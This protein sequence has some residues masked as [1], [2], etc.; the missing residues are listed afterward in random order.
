LQHEVDRL[1]VELDA[2]WKMIDKLR[3]QLCARDEAVGRD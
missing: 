3:E 2:A 1:E